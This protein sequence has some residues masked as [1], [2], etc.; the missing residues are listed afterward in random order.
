MNVDQ[1]F[2]L[3]Q[4]V[5]TARNAISSQIARGRCQDTACLTQAADGDVAVGLV[6][7]RTNSYVYVVVNDVQVAV[8]GLHVYGDVG[9]SV[10]ELAHQRCYMVHGEAQRGSHEKYPRGVECGRISCGLGRSEEH[11]SELQSLMR[12]SYAV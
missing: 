12:I 10:G 6:L 4:V 1:Q 11:K 7:A 9:V 8:G 3:L 5:Q 2:V